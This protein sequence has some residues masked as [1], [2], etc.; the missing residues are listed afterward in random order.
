[1]TYKQL[2]QILCKLTDEQLEQNITIKINDEFYPINE[3]AF[4]LK[5][6]EILD[7]GHFYFIK[8]FR[9]CQC[10]ADW[11][12][13]TPICQLCKLERKFENEPKID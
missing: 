6:N 3:F 11:T 4:A 8:S 2:F 7:E 13:G 10:L 12:D 5:E 9:F 1:M